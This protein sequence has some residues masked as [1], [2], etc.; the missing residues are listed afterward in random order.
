MK[1]EKS[2]IEKIKKKTPDWITRQIPTQPLLTIELENETSVPKVFY[3]GKE[4]EGKV[5]V[6]FDWVTRQ[7]KPRSGGTEFNIEHIEVV[8]NNPIQKGIGLVSGIYLDIDD[9]GE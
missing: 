5:R 7:S 9:Y 6:S 3:G 1:K 2:I 4:I 8:D